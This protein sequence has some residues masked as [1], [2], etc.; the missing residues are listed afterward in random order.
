[1]PWYVRFTPNECDRIT[2]YINNEYWTTWSA[3]AGVV[4][5]VLPEKWRNSSTIKV[6]CAVA[7]EGRNGSVDVMWDDAV[8]QEFRFDDDE[9]HEVDRPSRILLAQVAALREEIRQLNE[10]IGPM[11]VSGGQSGR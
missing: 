4:R 2:V 6:W 3:S 7:P 1:M 9:E 11:L 5:R 10:R 8:Q